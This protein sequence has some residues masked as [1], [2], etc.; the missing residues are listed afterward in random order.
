M[1]ISVPQDRNTTF[2]P[3][4]VKKRQKISQRLTQKSS[5]CMQKV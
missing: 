3:Q 4:V 1:E 2:E 5:L